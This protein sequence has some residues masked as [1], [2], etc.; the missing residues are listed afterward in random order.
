MDILDMA[1]SF[2]AGADEIAFVMA[3]GVLSFFYT[4]YKKC[5]E[6]LEKEKM[7]EQFLNE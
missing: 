1:M 7:L 5:D 4:A 6:E 2:R 3:L